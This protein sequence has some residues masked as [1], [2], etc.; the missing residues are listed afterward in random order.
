MAVLVLGHLL[1][2]RLGGTGAIW[3]NLTP[4]SRKGNARHDQQVERHMQPPK[5]QRVDIRYPRVFIY[6]VTPIYSR[7]PNQNLINQINSLA[8]P[9]SAP[10]KALKTS[11]VTSEQ[12]IPTGLKISIEQ[13]DESGRVVLELSN[14]YTVD[15]PI[16]ESSPADYYVR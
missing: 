1:N 16:D 6:V 4:L 14:T 9:D 2:E 10:I 13:R 11:V 15:S 8:N 12:Y 5:G 7:T 3:E